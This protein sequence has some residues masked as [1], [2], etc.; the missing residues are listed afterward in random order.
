[1][2]TNADGSDKLP[3]L[4]I[5]KS[6]KPRAFAN[7]NVTEEFGVEY[8]SSGKVW[9]NSDLFQDWLQALNLRTILEGRHILLLVDN[10]SSHKEPQVPLSNVRMEFL[11]KNTTSVLQ[12]LDQGVI[13][14]IKQR[15]NRIVSTDTLLGFR[16]RKFLF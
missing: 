2:A 8:T 13:A 16:S 14:C 12:P 3:L 5:G 4:F 11:P 1:M 7:H 10:V 6:V 9:M 15:F